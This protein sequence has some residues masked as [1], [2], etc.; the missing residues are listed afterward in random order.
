MNV[1]RAIGNCSSLVFIFFPFIYELTALRNIIIYRTNF[2]FYIVFISMLDIDIYFS[3]NII[4]IE[5][6]KILISFENNNDI[7]VINGFK[8]IEKSNNAV[9]KCKHFY[10]FNIVNGKILYQR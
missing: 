3:F 8:R 2:V 4:E 5:T 1:E 10:N 9:I 6:L 7:I